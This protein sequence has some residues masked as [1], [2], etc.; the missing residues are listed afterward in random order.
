MGIAADCYCYRTTARCWI[1]QGLKCET[2]RL[3]EWRFWHNQTPQHMV[4]L[5]PL[6][7]PLERLLTQLLHAWM[8]PWCDMCDTLPWYWAHIVSFLRQNK[9]I[10]SSINMFQQLP[11]DFPTSGASH[12]FPAY[13]HWV[14]CSAELVSSI[15]GRNGWPASLAIAIAEIGTDATGPSNHHRATG[16]LACPPSGLCIY[17]RHCLRERMGTVARNSDHPSIFNLVGTSSSNKF[18]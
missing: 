1:E 17:T 11:F 10:I 7:Y 6:P 4:F 16:Q 5:I 8:S 14:L 15:R 18:Q 13:R 3:W 2:E 12:G 9:N